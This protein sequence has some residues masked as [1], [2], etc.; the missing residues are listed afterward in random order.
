MDPSLTRL[1][2]AS[3]LVFAVA[4]SSRR[5]LLL[6]RHG[7]TR[8]RG[9][10]AATVPSSVTWDREA[11][12]QG[13]DSAESEDCYSVHCPDLPA[14]LRGTYFRNGPAKFKVGADQIQHP[15]DGDGMVAA[16]TFDGAGNAHFRNRFVRTAGFVEE[17]AANQMLY[18]GQFSPKAGGWLANAFDMRT[19][20]LANTNVMHWG[21]RLLA[22]WEGGKPTELDSRSLAT[23]NE[24]SMAGALGKDDNFTAHPRFDANTGRMVGFQYV[25]EPTRSITRVSFWEFEPDGFSVFRRVNHELPGFGF[26]HD[27]LV[28]ESYYI[29]SS[30]PVDLSGQ[31]A[32]EGLLGLRSMGESISFDSTRPARI[33]LVP[34]DGTE[35]KFVDV[36]SHFCFHFSNGFERDDGKVVIDMVRVPDFFLGEASASQQPVWVTAEMEDLPVSSLWRYELEPS[37]GTWTKRQLC[38]RYLDFPSVN[39][40]VSGRPYKHVFCGTTALD[41]RSGPLQGLVKIDVPEDAEGQGSSPQ[42]LWLPDSPAEFL[43]ES[44]F[45]PRS[46]ASPSSAREEEEDDG[47]IVGFLLNGESKRTDL[48]VFDAS[49]VAA[50]PVCRVPLRSFLPHGLHGSFVPDLVPSFEEIEGAWAKSA[51]SLP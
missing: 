25:P 9:V 15:F 2:A 17:L 10:A 3:G 24:S 30:A 1:S 26:Y 7:S 42:Q 20:N 48:V 19:K 43:G 33:V 22:L 18:R 50:G 35:I 5:R 32:L 12:I 36:D 31:R 28:T 49:S 38:D 51:T 46:R 23:V 47:Y 11:W 34:R 44:V 45:C 39:K 37:T 16:V 6:R 4:L 40:N 13:Y 41:G 14:D 21:G 27:F 8:C 29:L